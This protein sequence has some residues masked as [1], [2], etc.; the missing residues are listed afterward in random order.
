MEVLV[1]EP[2]EFNA[3]F[4]P[5]QC[6]SQ[7]VGLGSPDGRIILLLPEPEQGAKSR[8]TEHGNLLSETLVEPLGRPLL[9]SLTFAEEPLEFLGRSGRKR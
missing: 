4:V 7:D 9:A 1:R 8:R 6:V 5:C 3:A 2:D